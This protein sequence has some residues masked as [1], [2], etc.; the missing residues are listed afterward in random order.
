MPKTY[1]PAG[2]RLPSNFFTREQ[3]QP[4]QETDEAAPPPPRRRARRRSLRDN[5]PQPAN[6]PTAEAP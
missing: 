5:P 2:R 3:W 4:P 6:P 1:R